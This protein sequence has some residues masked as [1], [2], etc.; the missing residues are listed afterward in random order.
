MA[1]ECNTGLYRDL[2]GRSRYKLASNQDSQSAQLLR[3]FSTFLANDHAL[4]KRILM[5]QHLGQGQT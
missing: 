2:R 4:F 5:E 1:Q 3:Q